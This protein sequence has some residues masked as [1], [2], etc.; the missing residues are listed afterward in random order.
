MEAEART[1]VTVSD[2]QTNSAGLTVTWR[3]AT[4]E[5]VPRAQDSWKPKA[6]EPSFQED[7]TYERE[8]IAGLDKKAQAVIDHWVQAGRPNWT[9]EELDAVLGEHDLNLS[10]GP[11][12]S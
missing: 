5:E 12:A 9:K 3:I 2:L 6:Q 10:D 8:Y 7:A 1:T 11:K 4:R